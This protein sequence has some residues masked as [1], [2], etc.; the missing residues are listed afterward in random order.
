MV[1]KNGQGQKVLATFPLLSGVQAME[2]D[3]QVYVGGMPPDK[4]P[5]A[6]VYHWD[7]TTLHAL[8]PFP[9]RM[10]IGSLFMQNGVLHAVGYEL[11]DPQRRERYLTEEGEWKA[12]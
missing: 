4:G 9:G 5:S 8:D 10:P 6:E 7:G 12:P 3:G 2:L 1:R 11:G